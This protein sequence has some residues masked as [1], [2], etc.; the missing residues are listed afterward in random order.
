MP[1][2]DGAVL[3]RVGQRPEENIDRV[4]DQRM[5]VVSQMQHVGG[6]LEIVFRRDQID[7]VPPHLHPVFRLLHRHRRVFAQDFRQKTLMVRRQMLDDDERHPRILRQKGQKLLQRLEAGADADHTVRLYLQR[8][9]HMII[10][11]TSI[12]FLS[13]ACILPLF[14]DGRIRSLTGEIPF[15][16]K[17]FSNCFLHF[18]TYLS[19]SCKLSDKIKPDGTDPEPPGPVP[20]HPF[21]L[22][23]AVRRHGRHFRTGYRTYPDR[24]TG[25]P[26][27]VPPVRL[28][29]LSC[30]SLPTP[31]KR[32]RTPCCLTTAQRPNHLPPRRIP[33][34]PACCR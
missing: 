9:I 15:P 16:R 1:L 27:D 22:C 34:C 10:C 28:V 23:S 3:V 24:R 18:N 6:D 17:A 21:L 7:M 31:G 11:H 2:V 26:A 8:Y 12:L 30:L 33:P 20:C 25:R 19:E 29:L 5:I 14:P 32:Q 4:I 13:G